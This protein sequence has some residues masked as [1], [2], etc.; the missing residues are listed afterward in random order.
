MNKNFIVFEGVDAS[1][2]STAIET[3][4]TYCQE[5]SINAEFFSDPG[6]TVLGEKIRS[7]V[8]Y[9][10]EKE[11]LSP[12]AELLLFSAARAQLVDL[13]IVPALEA[14]KMVFCD[15]FILSTLVYQC[16]AKRS[17]YSEAMHGLSDAFFHLRPSL[18]L[19]FDISYKT[20]LQ[21]KKDRDEA[22]G[23]NKVDRF[24]DGPDGI[25]IRKVIEGYRFVSRSL[26]TYG[27]CRLI[28]ANRSKEEVFADVLS[29]VRE[30]E[31]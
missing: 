15:R 6:S 13:K 27:K 17:R 29:A 14:G 25:Y 10:L 16:Y 19:I 28:D 12:S 1:G 3:M 20:W 4:K 8:K 18:N 30:I 2:K 11:E 7:I 9:G 5:H 22:E 21:R 31:N 23:K 26:D 24:E